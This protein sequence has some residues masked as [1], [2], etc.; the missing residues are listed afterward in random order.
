M[1]TWLR[2]TLVTLTVGGG[3]LGFVYTLPMFSSTLTALK[4]VEASCSLLLYSFVTVSGLIFVHDPDSTGPLFGALALQVP[5]VSSPVVLYHFSTGL[6]FVL[7]GTYPQDAFNLGFEA[8]LGSTFR[9]DVAQA[10]P[11]GIGVN[12]VPIILIVIMV[13]SARSRVSQP[14][15]SGSSTA[16]ESDVS[17]NSI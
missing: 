10:H 7:K 16:T 2:L 9:F 8:F 12:L 17:L 13:K 3:F 5:W 11:W 14:T 1:K 4:F 6:K 15:Q